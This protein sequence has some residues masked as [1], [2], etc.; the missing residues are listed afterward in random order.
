MTLKLDCGCGERFAF[1]VEPVEGRMPAE[2]ACPACGRDMTAAANAGIADRQARDAG[3]GAGLRIA[4]MDDAPLEA[5]ATSGRSA[6]LRGA[7][8]A[9]R[10]TAPAEPAVQAPLGLW[11][12]FQ[13]GTALIAA[14]VA[15]WLWYSLVASK[16][17][18]ALTL[19]ASAE[20]PFRFAK[21]LDRG[22]CLYITATRVAAVA[23]PGGKPLWS[24][25]LS[26]D[27]QPVVAQGRGGVF[28]AADAVAVPLGGGLWVALA[29]K[30]VRFDLTTGRRGAEIVWPGRPQS[31]S[32]S[33]D[34]LVAVT[35]GADGALSVTRVDLRGGK[36]ATEPLEAR[37]PGGDLRGSSGALVETR[38]EPAGATVAILE[39]Q[40]VEA[41]FVTKEGEARQSRAQREAAP[42]L[43]RENLR[44]ADSVPAVSQWLAQR[45]GGPIEFDESR[46]RVAVE[47]H[48]GAAPVWSAEVT[49][50]PGLFPTGGIDLVATGANLLGLDRG[51]QARW[52]LP[53]SYPASPDALAGV[54]KVSAASGFRVFFADLGTVTA[55][56]S[57]D[58]RVQWRL[59]T[60]E[61][62]ELAVAG[63]A[64]WVST[65]SAGP[66]QIRPAESLRDD[67]RI[68]PVLMKVEPETGRI[69]WQIERLEHAI[70]TGSWLYG[71]GVETGAVNEAMA[72]INHSQATPVLT[73]KRLDPGDGRALWTWREP[74]AP[75]QV[76]AFETRVLIRR[77]TQIRVLKYLSL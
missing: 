71:Y 30:A 62:T 11:R 15:V 2:V 1:D 43:E 40:L 36:A 13:W 48:F 44:A 49:G 39:S 5:P 31:V 33:A 46:Y 61:T 17:S 52:S 35:E 26:K 72:A 20:D 42:L 6:A 14:L 66:E 63:G 37:F 38:V 53:L 64:L 70:A 55:L 69:D 41:R 47:R 16:P 29:D 28:E 58:G 24:A 19:T 45:K 51:N 9:A 21:L 3:A 75:A 77:A 12:A 4:R 18:V 57:R 59:P 54:A 8:R 25:E 7:E 50:R 22:R 32:A 34:A 60:V 74:G 73:L 76:D 68:H 56:D 23:V 27:E 65:T 10:A 67:S